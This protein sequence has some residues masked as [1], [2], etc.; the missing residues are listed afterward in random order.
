MCDI[1]KATFNCVK[2]LENGVHNRTDAQFAEFFGKELSLVQWRIFVA[3]FGYVLKEMAKKRATSRSPRVSISCPC[4]CDK[5]YEDRGAYIKPN[6]FRSRDVV[7][8]PSFY[9]DTLDD[10]GKLLFHELTHVYAYTR[11]IYYYYPKGD[12]WVRSLPGGG[13]DDLP[14]TPDNINKILRSATT[15]EYFFSR[16]CFPTLKKVK[17]FS[18]P[19]CNKQV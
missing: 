16:L 5:K 17:P 13:T 7:L 8:C 18:G 15:Y 19:G 14:G 12:K 1:H 10:Q 4:T 3:H 2:D 6:L 11:D 9:E